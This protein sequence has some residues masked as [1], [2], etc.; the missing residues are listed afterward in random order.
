MSYRPVS[1]NRDNCRQIRRN[2]NCAGGRWRYSDSCGFPT[3]DVVAAGTGAGPPTDV[4]RC[5][6]PISFMAGEPCYGVAT[7]DRPAMTSQ[8]QQRIRPADGA[9]AASAQ[10]RSPLGLVSAITASPQ[11]P[12]PGP[13]EICLIAAR[14]FRGGKAV[15]GTEPGHDLD[16][17]QVGCASTR[18]GAAQWRAQRHVRK[19]SSSNGRSTPLISLCARERGRRWVKWHQSGGERTS[20]VMRGRC[21]DMRASGNQLRAQSDDSLISLWRAGLDDQ[22]RVAGLLPCQRGELAALAFVELADQVVAMTS[23][24]GSA[25]ARSLRASPFG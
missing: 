4:R 17:V 3:P 16:L 23:S 25:T 24:T 21:H 9:C 12:A 1:A 18:V 6:W 10:R 13:R 15:R 14:H 8:H 19:F 5:G 7:C 2:I 11:A 22:Q 20:S